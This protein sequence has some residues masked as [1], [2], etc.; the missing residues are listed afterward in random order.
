[1]SAER[2]VLV[3]DGEQR[4]ALAV[5]RSLTRAGYSVHVSAGTP[6]AVAARSRG[7]TPHL[8]ATQPLV[9]APAYVREI[10][11]LAQRV[12]ATTVIPV[13]DASMEAMLEHH[14][15][16]P[17]SARLPCASLATYNAASDKL[18]VHEAAAAAGIA[19]EE[20]LVLRSPADGAPDD[21]RLYPGVVK[22]HRS[23]VGAGATRAKLAVRLVDDRAECQAALDALP[24]EAYPVLVQ[25]RVRGSGIGVFAGRWNGRTF[26][27]F[28]H[29]RVREKPPAGG[30]S[31]LSESIALP[32]AL[33]Q[34][35]ETLLDA[36]Q[37]Q[38]VAMVEC[39][40]DAERGGWRVM[41]I[42]GRFWGSL[43]LAIDSGVDFPA[44]LLRAAD[45]DT[46]PAPPAWRVGQ[47]LRWEWGDVDHL[48][49]RL[50]RSK[51]VL[52]LP[53]ETPGRM[54]AVMAFLGHRPFRDRFEV[55]RW[56]DPMPFVA[57]TLSWVRLVR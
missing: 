24:P 53:P 3:L 13:T 18:R 38:G 46:M 44:L 25:R 4:A 28:A 22:P 8:I 42:N 52:Q 57:E 41:E 51:A 7:A 55:L 43:Q 35:C 32:A 1:M 16:L 17:S 47:R 31:V 50:R 56:D 49:L 5:V 6:W 37:W 45:G 33:Q 21:P 9:D 39:K 48:L 34:A 30:V 14:A 26:A 11:Q 40:E 54:A 20:T 10:A 27:R 36:L 15:L 23:V 12:G 19:I 29:R 2:T